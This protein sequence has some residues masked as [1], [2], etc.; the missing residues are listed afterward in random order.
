[1]LQLTEARRI[2]DALGMT[3]HARLI[4]QMINELQ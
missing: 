2:C 1:V 4:Q 3:S